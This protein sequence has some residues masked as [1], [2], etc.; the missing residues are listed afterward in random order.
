MVFPIILFG[1][2]ML[3]VSNSSRLEV[4]I[5]TLA[6]QGVMLFILLTADFDKMGVPIFLFLAFE[7]LVFKTVIVPLILLKL[8]RKNEVF[9]EAPPSIPQ[10]YSSVI[11]NIIFAFGFV[12]A[13]VLMKNFRGIEPLYFGIS[14]STIITS[15][16]IMLIRKKLITHVM[17]YMMLENGIF[18]LS[19]SV[20][21]EMP[22]IVNLGVLLDI[23]V[24]IFIFALFISEMKT[25]F[26]VLHVDTLTDLKD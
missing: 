14:I 16:F 18:L 17:G 5:K 26:D 1:L 12:L 21:K 22:F 20:A 24:G 19:L 7:T 3:Y 25:S 8:I 2:S 13:F 15:L 11:A 10:F 23:F 6:F 9:R 4:Y